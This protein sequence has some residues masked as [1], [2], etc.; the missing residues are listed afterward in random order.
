MTYFVSLDP[1]GP[2]VKRGNIRPSRSRC[3]GRRLSRSARSEPHLVTRSGDILRNKGQ[4]E[5]TLS[6]VRPL[7][8]TMERTVCAP[9]G[10]R[11]ARPSLDLSSQN[12]PTR[13]RRWRHPFHA[14]LA[15]ERWRV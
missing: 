5:T 12:V 7:G 10:S 14:V 6:P 13:P 2:R 8:P 3:V 15:G 11:P 9:L 4:P 1:A